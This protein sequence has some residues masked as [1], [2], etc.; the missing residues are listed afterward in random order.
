VTTPY[1]RTRA[2]MD[3]RDFLRELQC[4]AAVRTE[5]REQ[6]RKLLRHYPTPA[7][8]QLASLAL[9]NSWAPVTPE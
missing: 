3:T 4:N 8:I 5:L 7:N 9:P 1:E 6:A 2:V